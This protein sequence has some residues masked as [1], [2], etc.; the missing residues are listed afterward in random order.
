MREI[1]KSNIVRK[2]LILEISFWFNVTLLYIEL[3]VLIFDNALLSVYKRAAVSFLTK[4][5]SLS[6][7]NLA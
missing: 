4:D 7:N 1:E 6:I 3:S 5:L 2:K